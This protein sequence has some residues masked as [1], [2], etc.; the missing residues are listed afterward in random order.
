MSKLAMDGGSP[1]HDSKARHWPR[2]PEVSEKSWETQ[3][4]H[5]REVYLSA[6]EGLPQ[7]RGRQFAEAFCDYLGAKHGLLTTSGTSALKLGLAAVTDTDGLGQN[8]ECIVPNYT[9]IASA[10]AAWEMGFS[11]RF[12]DID[13]ESACLCPKALEAAITPKT[14]V[15]MPVHI[16]GYPADMEA[17]LD[18]ARNHNLPVVEDACQ[19]HGA[20]CRGRKCGSIGDA[21]CF[22]FQS[23][24]NLTCGE[25]GFIATP[26]IDT[27]KLLYALHSVGRPPPGMS[28][29]EPRAGYSYRPSEYL[30]VLLENRLKE[31]DAQCERRNNAARYL[32]NELKGITGV[33]PAEV[34][35]YVTNHAYHLFPMRYT[36]SAFGGR[37]RAEFLKA[38]NAE[39]IPCSAGY[40]DLLSNHS[41]T[42]A[43]RK[44]H[45]ELV[46]EEPSPN[47]RRVCDESFWLFQSI[48]LA[49]ERDLADIPEAIRKIQT[50]FHA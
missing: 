19:A 25:G 28:F 4:R 33:R 18:V 29:D 45:P 44:R 43:V 12:V 23:S 31:L 32:T 24:K 40:S 2:W 13:P 47:T 9:F 15:I 35:E 41:M 1:V 21:G 37:P 17:I 46:A 10:H 26:S 48:L 11:V 3:A 49:D 22:S 14:R 5:W 36:P 39:G 42:N 38:M 50:A 6:T 34:K 7:P 27:Y 30:A 16:L 8:G 20:S